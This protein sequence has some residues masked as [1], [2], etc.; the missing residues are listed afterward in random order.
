MRVVWAPPLQTQRV[1]SLPS[2]DKVKHLSQND[3]GR[4]HL[5]ASIH[6]DEPLIVCLTKGELT[7]IIVS[8]SFAGL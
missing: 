6:D 8:S 1:F 2:E 7:L 5:Q 3:D 4:V